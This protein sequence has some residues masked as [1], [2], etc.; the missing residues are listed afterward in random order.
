MTWRKI[1]P[2]NKTKWSSQLLLKA[3]NKNI[4]QLACP[5]SLYYAV[6]VIF[7][8]CNETSSQKEELLERDIL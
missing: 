8:V 3:M 5:I 4:K 6:D 2:V 7:T 1:N